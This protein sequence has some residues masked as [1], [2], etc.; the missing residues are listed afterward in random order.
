LVERHM[1]RLP[2]A[3]A[4][5]VCDSLCRAKPTHHGTGC[6]LQQAE[7]KSL[8]QSR[9]HEMVRCNLVERHMARL[10]MA[11]ALHVCDSLC[12]GARADVLHRVLNDL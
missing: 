9:L 11:E 4:L 1:A 12:N 3:E 2:M 5:H 8:K 10:P 6:T 7:K